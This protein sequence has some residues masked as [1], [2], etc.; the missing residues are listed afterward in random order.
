M[1]GK[2]EGLVTLIAALTLGLDLCWIA[3]MGWQDALKVA[4]QPTAECFKSLALIG[5][6]AML[7]TSVALLFS[8]WTRPFLAGMLTFGYFLM[9]RSIFPLQE[10]L[11]AQNGP[12]TKAGPIRAIAQAF[13]Y[14]VPDL[15]T[16]NVSRELA[17]SIPVPGDY[18]FASAGYASSFTAVFLVL[19]ITLFSRRDFV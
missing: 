8:S 10:H 1:L 7:V 18:L 13:A 2:F 11:D 17:L 5:L 3:S 15:Q 12:L 4:D 19:G 16:F 9:G 6:E 14:L